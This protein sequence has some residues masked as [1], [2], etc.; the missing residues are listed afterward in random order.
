M[1]LAAWHNTKL[2]SDSSTGQ[3]SNT[4]VTGLKSRY[5]SQVLGVRTQIS[6][7]HYYTYR[8]MCGQALPSPPVPRWSAYLSALCSVFEPS[9][10]L[11]TPQQAH[12][13]LR[14]F[15]L[16]VSSAQKIC[17][18]SLKVGHLSFHFHKKAPSQK[19]LITSRPPFNTAPIPGSAFRYFSGVSCVPLPVGSY[20]TV[21]T[22]SAL[23]SLPNVYRVPTVDPF[24][25]CHSSPP[26]HDPMRGV[27]LL[28][29]P[30]RGG[31]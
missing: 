31:N 23:S 2:L 6:G 12:F 29:P 5:N 15:A 24:F 20:A 14:T 7:G 1:N 10:F 4:G 9:M 28:S 16:A 13:Y 21:G 18:W 25:A 30:F 22:T 8:A 26:F 3:K 27:C 17:P 11:L 19:V